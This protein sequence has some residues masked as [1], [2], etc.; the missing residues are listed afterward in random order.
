LI[1]AQAPNHRGGGVITSRLDFHDCDPSLV[2]VTTPVISNGRKKSG[3]IT[4]EISARNA[5]TTGRL[6]AGRP[7]SLVRGELNPD[8]PVFHNWPNN[9]C[10]ILPSQLVILPPRSRVIVMERIAG[11]RQSE[12]LPRAILVEPVE[13]G[14]PGAY[15]A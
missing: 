5:L 15:V 4:R 7:E 3:Q 2:T 9:T 14:S 11:E 6:G 8:S 1:Y 10:S 12:G 13:I